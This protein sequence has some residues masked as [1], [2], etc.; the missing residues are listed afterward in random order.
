MS[1]HDSC[2]LFLKTLD[3]FDLK[4]K[5]EMLTSRTEPSDVSGEFHRELISTPFYNL[6]LL[7][8]FDDAAR[9]IRKLSKKPQKPDWHLIQNNFENDGISS[10]DDI[11]V[12]NTKEEAL[13]FAIEEMIKHRFFPIKAIELQN[14]NLIFEDEH[15]DVVKINK[16]SFQ[17]ARHEHVKAAKRAIKRLC[18]REPVEKVRKKLDKIPGAGTLVKNGHDKEREFKDPFEYS[19]SILAY[20]MQQFIKETCER[21][22]KLSLAQELCIRFFGVPSWNYLKKLENDFSAFTQRPFVLFV[23]KESDG[24]K[25]LSFYRDLSSG[26]IGFKNQLQYCDD[27]QFVL[28]KYSADRIYTELKDPGLSGHLSLQLVGEAMPEGHYKASAAELLASPKFPSNVI[29]YFSSNKSKKQ[30]VIEVN[31]KIGATEEEHF[32]YGDW[33]FWIDRSC[34]TTKYQYLVVERFAGNVVKNRKKEYVQR[35]KA[36]IVVNPDDN[37]YWMATDWN[38]KPTFSLV[39][40]PL[41]VLS[42]IEKKFI[43]MDHWILNTRNEED[44]PFYSGYRERLEAS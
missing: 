30:R 9:W 35:M 33:F 36:A 23:E 7:Y 31:A 24:F 8:R 25:P 39:G 26:L 22:I 28:S 27:K 41:N 40:I 5:P 15:G 34:K 43:D 38:G 16:V 11:C 19:G 37:Q 4:I 13:S 18:W 29:D 3:E 21:E 20:Q 2:L 32:F 44:K 12:A 14:Q 42:K 17:S 6:T 1:L 10:I